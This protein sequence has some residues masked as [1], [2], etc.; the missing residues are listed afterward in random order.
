MFWSCKE[1]RLKNHP[2]RQYNINDI[3]RLSGIDD[4]YC[5]YD[6]KNWDTCY[7]LISEHK[8]ELYATD[9][10]LKNDPVIQ[11]DI[12]EHRKD[13]KEF[14]MWKAANEWQV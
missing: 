6:A 10:M 11:K 14:A 13:M 8:N 2:D 1:Q 3:R 5:I 9:V 7:G 12:T 4:I